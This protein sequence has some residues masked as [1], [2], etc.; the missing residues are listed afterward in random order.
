[1]ESQAGEIEFE[2]VGPLAR[3]LRTV[4]INPV[5]NYTPPTLMRWLLRATKSELAAANWAD[6]GGW[7]SMVISY[8]GR[9]RQW[10]DKVLVGN[11]AV[12]M[13]LRNRRRLAG[14][15]LANLI[16]ACPRQPVEVVCVGAGPGMIP[17]DA[18]RQ[19]RRPARATLIDLSGA[20]HDYARELARREGLSQSVRCITGDACQIAQHIDGRVDIVEMIGICEYLRDEQ[21]VSIVRTLTDVMPAAGTVVFNSLSDCH[22]TDRFFRRV[23]GLHMN[24]RSVEALCGLMRQAGL[25]EFECVAEPLGV[26]HVVTAR[27]VP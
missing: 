9:C 21:I 11:G 27:K 5:A 19:A 22:G 15:V 12:P 18:L 26:Y 4:L 10:S 14:R 2:R 13:A 16:D 7:R 1:M 3:F 8:Q 25:G 20:A 24:H 23:F 17:I 6:P